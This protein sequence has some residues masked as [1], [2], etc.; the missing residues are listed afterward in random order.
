MDDR[1]Y[2]QGVPRLIE[3]VRAAFAGDLAV[4]PP[5][6]LRGGND[7]DSYRLA[8]AYEVARDEPTD[9]YLAQHAFWGLAYLDAR[10]W[11]H[12]LPHLIGY[13]LRHAED[14]P[15]MVTEALLRSLQPPD[16]YPPRLATLTPEQ[17]TVIREFLELVAFAPEYAAQQEQAQQALEEWWLPNP[18][19]RPTPREIAEL[20]N[21]PISYRMV[22]GE[23]YQFEIPTTLAG[24]GVR[25]IPE[26]SREVETWGGYLCG[27]AHTVVAVNVTPLEKRSFNDS[28]ALRRGLF[29]EDVSA[30]AIAVHGAAEAKRMDGLA[31][32]DSPAEPQ[33]LTV[34]IARVDRTIVTLTVR[35]WPR[36]D[37]ARE[38]DRIVRSFAV[39]T[40]ASNLNGP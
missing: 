19:S 29:L 5:L 28:I 23:L 37:L 14:D 24:S 21:S 38:A 18:R 25:K 13:A 10:S 39:G 34:V 40:H 26:E 35:T 9:E 3:R 6:S 20:R 12:Y 11:R 30:Q 33:L 15:H 16:R 4:Q 1:S 22:A 17:E 27:D 8:A 32:G 36:E 7:V 31:H 2:D